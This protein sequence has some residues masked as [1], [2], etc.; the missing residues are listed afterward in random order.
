MRIRSILSHSGQA[1][2]EGALVASIVVGVVAGTALAGKP[3]SSGTTS[4][5]RVDDGVFAGTTLAH[6][7]SSS[8]TWV[9]AKCFQG[10]TLV[11]EQ[12]RKYLAD[13][14]TTLSLGPTPLWSA[15]SANC[16]AQEGSYVRTTRWRGSGSTTFSV[17]G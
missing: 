6:R 2:L 8:A 14:T 15:G 16:T 4:T 3:G 12:W 11:F 7:G 1:L 17:S 13:G 5:F 10:G 9:H